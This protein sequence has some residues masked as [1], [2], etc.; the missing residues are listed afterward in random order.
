MKGKAVADPK[1]PLEVLEARNAVQIAEWA[2][3]DR[4]AHDSFQKAVQLLDEAENYQQRKHPEKKSAAMIAREAVQTADD[5][6][7]ITL[8][9]AQEEDLAQ[10]RQMAAD[11]EASAKAQ[12]DAEGQRRQQA[13]QAQAQAQQAAAQAQQ[14]TA[15]AEQ[16]QARLEAA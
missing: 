11:R 4:Y 14:A 8:K 15:K 9:R 2:G 3:A 5:A 13:E 1:R 7:L 12:A 16:E 6:R 10:D